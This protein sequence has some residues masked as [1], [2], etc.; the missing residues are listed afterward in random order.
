M[1]Q[2]GRWNRPIGE[3]ERMVK[4]WSGRQTKALDEHSIEMWPF[5]LFR[6]LASSRQ[7]HMQAHKSTGDGQTSAVAS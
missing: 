5:L 7:G 3:S 1:R 6:Q 2:K 4:G